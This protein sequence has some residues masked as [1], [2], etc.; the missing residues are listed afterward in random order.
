ML[1]I[2]VCPVTETNAR[3]VAKMRQAW[4]DGTPGPDFPGGKGESD[5]IDRPDVE[6]VRSVGNAQGLASIG[7]EPLPEPVDGSEGEKEVVRK[8]NRILGFF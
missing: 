7:L 6:F 8:A 4:R 1:Y 5:H 2:P 3:Y